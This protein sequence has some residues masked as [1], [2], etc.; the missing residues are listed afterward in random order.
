MKPY[1]IKPGNE[2]IVRSKSAHKA[3]DNARKSDK[4]VSHRLARAR[5]KQVL[6]TIILED[7]QGG[8]GSAC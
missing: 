5:S 3:K 1:G 4:K 2:Y 6:I 7:G 8:N